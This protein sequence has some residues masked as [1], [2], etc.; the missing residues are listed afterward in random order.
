[1]IKDGHISDWIALGILA[2]VAFGLYWTAPRAGDWWWSDAPRHALN[3]VF[4]GDLLAAFPIHNPVQWASE[5]YVLYPAL[6]I[7]FYPPL[8]YIMSAPFFMLFGVSES[9]AMIPVALCY[10]ALIFG[11]YQL[12]K[13][14]FVSPLALGCGLLISVMP[15]I[16]LWGRQVM[17]EIPT[18]AFLIWSIIF[19]YRYVDSHI[20][21]NLYIGAFLLLC[22]L[23][24][25]QTV[26]WIIPVIAILLLSYE[27]RPLLRA[28]HVWATAL[29]FLIGLVPLIAMTVLLGQTN[30]QS[31]SG[32]ADS[33]VSR[34]SLAGWLWYAKQ[35]PAQVTWLVWVC[36]V[37]GAVAHIYPQYRLPWRD[38]LFLGLWF[39]VGYVAYS[40]VD[41]KEQRLD[42]FLVLPIVI[43]ASHFVGRVEIGHPLLVQGLAL[44]LLFYAILATEV[45]YVRGYREAADMVARLAPANSS[46]LISAKRDGSFVFNMRAAN[47]PD[48]F[49]LR[50]DKLLLRLAVRRE[51]G[52]EERDY[53]EDEIRNML[54]RYGVRYVVAQTDFWTD[55]TPMARL[56]NMLRTPQYFERVASIPIVSNPTVEDRELVIY[57]NLGEVREGGQ[58][59]LDLPIIGRSV[60]GTLHK[61]L[62]Q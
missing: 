41:L 18:F 7:L 61:S 33:E 19:F 4:I 52:V 53:S 42:L 34:Y 58:I 20:R 3:G 45:P 59:Q 27:G 62:S 10:L 24:T 6:T 26:V 14:W 48:L 23:Y 9:V 55:L 25:K 54:G 40:L 39:V 1:M 8:F 29:L 56:Q 47:R 60:Q 13:R 57:K 5:Y 51:L 30:I 37:G 22:A 50:A 12:S 11:T 2:I 28:R 46:V 21:R 16:T 15:V 43:L 49:T 17:L 38:V 32:I 44:G 31:V 36:A 35:I